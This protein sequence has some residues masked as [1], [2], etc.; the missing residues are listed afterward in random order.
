M[1]DYYTQDKFLL[2]VDQRDKSDAN[3][4]IDDADDLQSPWINNPMVMANTNSGLWSSCLSI[5]GKM[6]IFYVWCSFNIKFKL[7]YE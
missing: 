4:D 3:T 2:I 6:L 1:D 5:S 7:F